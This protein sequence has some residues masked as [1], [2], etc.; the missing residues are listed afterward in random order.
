MFSRNQPVFT[1]YTRN[2]IVSWDLAGSHYISEHLLFTALCS[3]FALHLRL[4][5]ISC[6]IPNIINVIMN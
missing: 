5:R 1:R 4:P 3:L 6:R 2:H